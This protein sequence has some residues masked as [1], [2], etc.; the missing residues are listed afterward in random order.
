MSANILSRWQAFSKMLLDRHPFS[1]CSAYFIKQSSKEALQKKETNKNVQYLYFM[2]YLGFGFFDILIVF[3]T[4]N[5]NH[6]WQSS[7]KCEIG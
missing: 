3:A 2:Y 6:F 1:Y 5:R 4:P 7:A